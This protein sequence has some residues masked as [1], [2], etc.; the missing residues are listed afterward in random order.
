MAP[1]GKDGQVFY[2]GRT[3]MYKEALPHEDRLPSTSHNSGYMV[4]LRFTQIFASLR[5]AKTSYSRKKLC[6]NISLEIYLNGL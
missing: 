4:P 6:E 5:S 2:D 1:A 3:H